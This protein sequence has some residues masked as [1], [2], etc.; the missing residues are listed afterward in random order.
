MQDPRTADT[1]R[2]PPATD[3]PPFIDAEDHLLLARLR[4]G[5]D[6]AFAELVRLNTGRLLASARRILRSDEEARD[7]VQD[8]F[9]QAFRGLDGFHGEARLSTWLQRIAINASLMRLRTRRR[10]PEV[11][12]EE[13]LP[14]FLEDGH[15]ADPGAAWSVSAL[16]ALESDETR[17]LVRA[18]I[19]RLPE[20]Y[21]NVLLL[22]DIEDLDTEET[23]MV[24]GISPGAAK[25][26]L[27]RAR[28]ALRSLLAPHFASASV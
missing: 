19:E 12:I 14:Q 18:Q 11:A 3:S 27:H 21:R 15:R 24:L 28:Q 1:E 2:P 8:A 22:R 23:A 17:A 20:D 13:L 25:V 5:E 6:A 4:A 26:R 7:A 10:K 16:E 9:L